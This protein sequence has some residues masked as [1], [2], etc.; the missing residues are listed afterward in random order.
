MDAREMCVFFPLFSFLLFFL[1]GG[2]WSMMM[3]CVGVCVLRVGGQPIR[4]H[5]WPQCDLV[6]CACVRVCV[7]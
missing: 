1:G 3:M 4:Q 6:C 5:W 7:C 2:W